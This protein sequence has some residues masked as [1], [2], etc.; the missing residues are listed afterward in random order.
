MNK[1][2]PAIRRGSTNFAKKLDRLYVGKKRRARS[3][4]SLP[5]MFGQGISQNMDGKDTMATIYG[6]VI[7][8]IVTSVI[9]YCFVNI[10]QKW[11]DKTNPEITPDKTFEHDTFITSNSLVDNFYQR[12]FFWDGL[13]MIKA[14]H[15]VNFF[16]IHIFK[17]TRTQ[18]TGSSTQFFESET[19]VTD[20]FRS[21]LDVETTVE[22]TGEFEEAR[23]MEWDDYVRC[24]LPTEEYITSGAKKEESMVWWKILVYLCD[25]STNLNCKATEAD[26]STYKTIELEVDFVDKHLNLQDI[27]EP[28]NYDMNTLSPRT[29]LNLNTF[30]IFDAYFDSYKVTTDKNYWYGESTHEVNFR[31]IDRLYYDIQYRDQL[32]T[33][34]PLLEISFKSGNLYHS[35]Q[36]SYKKMVDV[37]GDMGGILE[38]ITT[39]FSLFYIKYNSVM[40]EQEL[41]NKS[42]LYM[43][44]EELEV[45]DF[46]RHYFTFCEQWCRE[47][48]NCFCCCFCCCR[49]KLSTTEKR[50]N[51]AKEKLDEDLNIFSII[52]KMHRYE[53]LERLIIQPYQM[54]LFPMAF[55]AMVND[56]YLDYD[57]DIE[58]VEVE[59]EG[60]DAPV[61][62]DEVEMTE[63][64]A[65]DTLVSKMLDA[66][67]LDAIEKKINLWLINVLDIDTSSSHQQDRLSGVDQT[68]LN[69]LDISKFMKQN[70][71][72][73]TVLQSMNNAL[74]QPPVTFSP[75]GSTTT[76]GSEKIP[77]NNS[78]H[79]RQSTFALGI[80]EKGD[81][82]DQNQA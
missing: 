44:K 79:T 32:S 5:D 64:E 24:T 37:L 54:K 45:N 17:V 12:M 48:Y 74:Y 46:K 80:E 40:L 60:G 31:K 22:V 66:G 4:Y 82:S 15:W 62:E 14:K 52:K 53:I 16:D 11:A 30:K 21:C 43:P 34:D 50:Y 69:C 56:E 55:V 57:K 73:K 61:D 41:L 2:A 59:K 3:E 8:I 49:K 38:I 26:K 75:R 13:S 1:T 9:L 36:R 78:T 18:S 29:Q 19:E 77:L 81:D 39:I 58:K 23:G 65:A 70:E 63:G 76:N 47:M 27:D 51:L 20:P 28:V 25:S 10:I 68:K 71:I 7:T 33:T 35:Y 42:Q 72:K 6:T 67:N